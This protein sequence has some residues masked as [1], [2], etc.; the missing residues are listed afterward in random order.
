MG[1]PVNQIIQ[2]DC[3]QV[4]RTLPDKSVDLVLTDQP[5]GIGEDGGRSEI[6]RVVVIAS[7]QKG[8]GIGNAV[9]GLFRRN[10]ASL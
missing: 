2:G 8:T 4:L 3:L 6:G 9:E 7:F 1:L 10:V 5:Y